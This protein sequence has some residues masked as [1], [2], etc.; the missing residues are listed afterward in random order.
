MVT[1]S[2]PLTANDWKNAAKHIKN[3]N[4]RALAK[5]CR[6]AGRKCRHPKGV[7]NLLL[8]LASTLSDVVQ[9]L[10]VVDGC[11]CSVSGTV[12]L[13]MDAEFSIVI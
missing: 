7:W 12:T 11:Y 6:R 2:S 9:E 1:P 8:V 4:Q 3:K 13:S 5:N 10:V